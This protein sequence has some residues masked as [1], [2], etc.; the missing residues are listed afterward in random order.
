MRSV[1]L[2]TLLEETFTVSLP[3]ELLFDPDVTLVTI[4]TSLRNGGIANPRP[5]MYK[6][7]EVVDDLR[8]NLT[9]SRSTVVPRGV[10]PG[11]ILKKHEIKANI[12]TANFP[13]A[14]ALQEATFSPHEKIMF[15]LLAISFVGVFFWLP[16]ILFVFFAYLPIKVSTALSVVL[17]SLGLG[18]PKTRSWP[19]QF[20]THYLTYL[21][22]KFFSYRVIR[23]DP[24]EVKQASIYSFHPHGVFPIPTALQA[25]VNEFIV[26]ESFHTLSASA[27]FYIPFYASFLKALAYKDISRETFL[28]TLTAGR[29]V[30][31]N[32]GGIA[33]MFL[34]PSSN[35]GEKLMMNNR[36]GFIKIALETGSPIIPVF[37]YGHSQT[38]SAYT[39]SL[40]EY[41]S[42]KYR[43]SLILFWG[44]YGVPIPYRVPLCS[45]L[46]RAINCPKVENPSPEL[47]HEYYELYCCE[48]QRLYKKYSN[49]YNWQD[50]KLSIIKQATNVE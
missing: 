36:K 17:I 26:G 5:V 29:S 33:E 30:A 11:N 43:L 39:N 16:I 8:A 14:C 28:S 34:L 49:T 22:L 24:S 48:L 41:L 40:L 2:Q 27:V 37:T 7:W 31:L 3:D 10:L 4:A 38:F 13:D 25:V 6:A 23:E 19:P 15:A 18:Y 21:S 46:G 42:R 50:R 9:K 32:P 1:Q 47:I 20:R 45:V 12:D 44:M 35:E